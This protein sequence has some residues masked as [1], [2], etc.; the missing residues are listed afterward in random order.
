MAATCAICLTVIAKSQRFVLLG[1]EALHAKCARSGLP[2]VL[3]RTQSS[4]ATA[5]E[6][7]AHVD[8]RVTKLESA[9]K[10]I[11][12]Q[13]NRERSELINQV[14]RIATLERQLELAQLE[15]GRLEVNLQLLN[16]HIANPAA[17]VRPTVRAPAPVPE[18]SEGDQRGATEIR[19]SL[20]ELD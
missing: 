13:D 19:F 14:S 4:L 2:T 15:V 18:V 6:E 8:R 3:Q 7:I 16:L 5:R 12:E 10:F 17:S 1:T 20:L 11:T 9:A